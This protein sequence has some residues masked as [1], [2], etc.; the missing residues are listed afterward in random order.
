MIRPMAIVYLFLRV[1][2]L[3]VNYAAATAGEPLS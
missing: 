1:G 3:P 2:L